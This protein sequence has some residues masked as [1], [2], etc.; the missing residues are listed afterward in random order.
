MAGFLALT[1]ALASAGA[2]TL[3]LEVGSP[4]VDLSSM[5]PHSAKVLVERFVDGAWQRVTEWTNQL[6][7][8]DS[9]GRPVHRWTTIG[10][11]PLPNGGTAT[12]TLE[13]T[14]DKASIRPLGLWR[15]TSDG[16]EVRLTF[17]GSKV[18]GTRR[19]GP[20]GAVTPVEVQLSRAAYPAGASDLV[21]MGVK[22]KEGLVM[23]APVWQMGMPDAETRIF[24]VVA[25]RPTP[26]AGKTWNAWVV[27]ERAV[28]GSTQVFIGT[29]YVV[30]EIPYMIYAAVVGPDGGKQRMTEVETVL[31]P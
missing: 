20:D 26:V 17:D 23:T 5:K 31:K 12:W 9:A 2:D 25:R 16:N 30:D 19:V 6:K 10:S 28:R 29:W 27:E 1:L 14:F 11:R 7:V 3:R 18:R 15:T 4:E 8:G 13:Q 22:L 21:P 24:T